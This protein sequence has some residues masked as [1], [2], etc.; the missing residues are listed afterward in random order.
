MWRSLV[1]DGMLG[2][3]AEDHLD[4]RPPAFDPAVHLHVVT[5]DGL[6]I[7]D[8]AT[9]ADHTA[10]ADTILRVPRQRARDP[11]C[12]IHGSLAGGRRSMDFSMGHALSLV[13]RAEYRLSHVLVNPPFESQADFY[14]PPRSARLLTLRDGRI[15]PTDDARVTL[16]PASLARLPPALT[17]PLLDDSL[18]FETLILRAQCALSPLRIEVAQAAREVHVEGLRPLQL[19]PAL[20]GWYA[21]FATRRHRALREDPPLL[22]SGMVYVAKDRERYFGL[23]ADLMAHICRRLGTETQPSNLHGTNLR[24]SVSTINDQIRR[25]FDHDIGCRISIIGPADRGRRDG[26]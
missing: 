9:A 20:I 5:R 1:A 14:F 2:A 19:E 18:D 8:I 6:A 17:E 11:A 23:G 21:S 22:A 10:V 12:A 26:R 16:A 13:A 24:P 3:L 15:V 7:D 4:G 25:A